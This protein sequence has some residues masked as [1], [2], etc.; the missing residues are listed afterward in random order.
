MV[1]LKDR[2]FLLLTSGKFTGMQDEAD[3]DKMIRL[4]VLNITYTVASFLILGM[5]VSDMRSGLIDQGLLQLILGFMVFSNL[6][7]LR[8]ELPFIVGG[9]IVIGLFGVF[10]GIS[11]FTKN[12]LQGFSSIWIYSYPL[13]SIFT[14]GLSAGL[15]PA[16]LL[17]GVTAAGVFIPGLTRFPYTIP[18]ALLICGVYIFVLGLTIVYEYV[19]SIKDRWL[20]QKDSYMNMVFKNSPDI[21]L[22]F[23]KESRMVYSAD[24]FLKG[25]NLKNIE[26]IR[27]KYY[28][29]V[30]ALF[31]DPAMLN[32]ISAKF[33]KSEKEKSPV[34]LKELIDVGRN[35]NPRNY[36]IHFTPM[37]KE[38]IFQGAFVLFHD[39][40]EILHAKEKAEQASH[41]K[42]NFL[43]NMSH[44]IR[45]PM[46]AIIGMTTI[47]K[48]TKELERKDYCFDKI[49]GASTHL[50]GVI[51]DILDMSKIEADK[52]ELSGTEFD[53]GKMLNRVINV[54]EFRLTEK[55]QKL[56][57]NV[58]P[59]IP[60]RI[61]S[62]EQRLAQ[63]ITNL[64]TNAVKF[65]PE[66]GSI[67]IDAKKSSG[68]GDNGAGVDA[69]CVLEIRVTDTGIGI[70]KEQQKK[71]FQSFAQVDS[72]ISRKFGGTGLGLVI[73]KQIVEMMHGT[74]R[75]ESELD[76]GSSFIFTVRVELPAAET[77]PV[78][79]R[80]LPTA[81]VNFPLSPAS[82]SIQ[83]ALPAGNI[84]AEPSPEPSAVDKTSDFS[85]YRILLAE[86]VDINREI[87]L[88]IL[89]PTGL[90]IDEAE[91]GQIAYNK[92]TA[93]P[94]IYNL[95][96]MDIHM[97]EV[98]GYEA[99]RLIREFDHPLAQKIPIIAMTANV[100]KE[101]VE[102][103][104]AAGMN[105][106]IGKPLNFDEVMIVLQKYLIAAS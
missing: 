19:R 89:E 27:K 83:P 99:T 44:E 104:L 4:I 11:I 5:G 24:V 84:S 20:T 106:H 37:Y 91:D 98:D 64:L 102:K 31:A 87:V 12:N 47:G 40:T 17:L 22:L 78:E 63:V 74:I 57:V 82:P 42:S 30:F 55:K 62:D 73:S 67:T 7:L 3:M 21:I 10:C 43:A 8:T 88:T 65:T 92:F 15:I 90:N 6:L 95:I 50:L 1:S 26:P 23:D 59:E 35:G 101:D 28:R 52:F 72:S 81:R 14:L 71:L 58:A 46:N 105:D 45:T 13:M 49:D 97:P 18:E 76:K 61:I 85:G 54:L 32:E 96:F 75:I 33:M 70:S 38:G 69:F 36:E 9:L 77:E 79:S 60:L 2:F 103:C 93:N 48:A 80:P 39:M 25:L 41:A 100:F 16:L 86:D 29:D 56:T 51:N 94:E 53:F 34:V 66:E 68:G